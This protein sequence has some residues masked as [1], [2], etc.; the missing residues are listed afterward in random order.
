TRAS[1]GTPSI[2][3]KVLVLGQRLTTGTV[4][5]AVPTRITNDGAAE[6]SFGRG[7][8]LAEMLKAARKAN[9][10]IELWGLALDDDGAGVKAVGK[11]S[12]VASSV[13]AG[14]LNLY[15]GGKR[16]RVGVAASATA[17]AIA[18]AAIAAINADTTLPVTAVVN[19]TNAYEVD[20]TCR[21]KGE[22]GNAIDLRLN[23]Y[24]GEASPTG[25]TT[26]ITA[27]STGTANPDVTDAIVAFGP[28][29][30]NYVVMPWM[31]TANLNA[32]AAEM[33]SRWGAM[34]A[35]DGIVFAAFRGTY[36]TTASFGSARN[37]YPISCMGTGASPTA[38]WIWAAVNAT[39]AA[40]SLSNDPARPLR[41]L[42]LPGVLAPAVQDRFIDEERNLLLFDGISTYESRTD[43]T[44]A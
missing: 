26:T 7:S 14:T 34:R 31:D 3:H 42:D 29:W 20:L 43:G 21:W 44:V 23:Y 22:T 16:V 38:P 11:L 39:V 41:T 15:I 10:Y 1:T 8:M 5:A 28:E 37:D 36:G 4:A 12:F 27:M 6:A 33:V 2:S 13:V 18:T 19:G 35:I 17:A 32:L 9:P 40:D 30:W 25:L 24:T